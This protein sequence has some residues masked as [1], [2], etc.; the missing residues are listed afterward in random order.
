MVIRCS[1][2]FHIICGDRNYLRLQAKV[3][4]EDQEK[5]EEDEVNGSMRYIKLKMVQALGLV[6]WGI[7]RQA[8]SP[9]QCQRIP[10]YG[11]NFVYPLN[12]CFYGFTSKER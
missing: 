9:L 5:E 11:K 2:K 10:D 3:E 7:T 6:G 4:E 1:S 8:C 12:D